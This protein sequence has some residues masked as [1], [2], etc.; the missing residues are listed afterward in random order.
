MAKITLSVNKLLKK[1]SFK[2]SLLVVV[3]VQFQQV[4]LKN[5]VRY[6]DETAQLLESM[7][8][9]KNVFICL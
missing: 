8:R 3:V 6:K 9:C 4:Y 7:T 1:V 5:Q 2:N